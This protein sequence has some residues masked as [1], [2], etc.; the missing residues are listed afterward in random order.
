MNR[1]FQNAKAQFSAQTKMP[2]GA[3]IVGKR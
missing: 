1:D 2:A 3:G